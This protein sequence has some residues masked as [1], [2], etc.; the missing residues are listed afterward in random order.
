MIAGCSD[1][2]TIRRAVMFACLLS[3]AAA[4]RVSLSPL[5][6]RIGVGTESYLIF[7]A[8]GEGGQG[9][10]YAASGSGGPVFPVTFTRVHETAPALSPDGL[11]LAYLRGRTA[12]DSAGFRIWVMNLL[13]GN[14]RE[15]PRP[16]GGHPSH[17]GWSSDGRTLF[18][19]TS[20]GDFQTPAPPA[21]PDLQPADPAA[22]AR[23]LS[24]V[25]GDP[26]FARVVPC[27]SAGL[28]VETPGGNRSVLTADGAHPVRWGPDSVGYFVGSIFVVRPL[29]AGQAREVEW[30]KMPEGVGEGSGFGG[31]EK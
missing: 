18:I 23:A 24:V 20:S 31:S 28:C 6:N 8:R 11:M 5:Q 26:V 27:D 21:R 22:A 3:S 25:L 1:G 19:R 4:C 13:N 15:I 17:L 16:G 2:R 7:T 30:Q 10:L 12:E 14:E 29:G 9:D